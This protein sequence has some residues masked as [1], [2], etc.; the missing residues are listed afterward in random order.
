M[1]NDYHGK[2][3]DG[4]EIFIPSWTVKVQYENLTQACKYLGQ[5]NVVTISAL[6]VAAAVLAVMGSDDAEASTQLV[7]HFTQQARIEGEKIT[8]ASINELGMFTVIELFAHVMY[9]QYNDFFVSGLAK[10]RCQ[11]KSDQDKKA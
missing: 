2:L 1:S 5:D 4:R 8:P 10:A 9:S 3:D 7:I 11:S 6:N